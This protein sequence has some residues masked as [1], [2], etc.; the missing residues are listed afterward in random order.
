DTFICQDDA[1]SIIHLFLRDYDDEKI[2]SFCNEYPFFF[3]M[4]EQDVWNANKK[5]VSTYVPTNRHLKLIWERQPKTERIIRM[6]QSL[7]DFGTEDSLS[8]SFGGKT[9]AFYVLDIPSENIPQFQESVSAFPTTPELGTVPERI[10]EIS[11]GGKGR[12]RGQFDS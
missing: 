7:R 8:F 4:T 12:G 9:R 5:A 6:F 11:R 1:Y 2:L 3:V 10:P